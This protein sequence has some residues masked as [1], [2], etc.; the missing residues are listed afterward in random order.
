M[1]DYLTFQNLYDA[2]TNA[3]KD[4]GDSKLDTVKHAIN[5]TYFEMLSADDVYPMFWLLDFDDT[6]NAL[7]EITISSITVAD[8]GVITASAVHGLATSDIVSVYGIVGTMS[9]LNNRTYL[10]NSVPLTTTLSLIDLDSLD[11]IATTGL[12]RTSGGTIVHRGKVLG[13]TGKNV[14]RIH[15]VIFHGE[16]EHLTEITAK[17]LEAETKWW[18]SST[19]RPMRYFHRKRYS[20]AGTESNQLLWFPGSDDAYDL[21]Y[22]FEGRPSV[23]SAVGDVPLMPPQ[24]HYGISAGAIARLA[25]FNVQVENQVIWPAIY[26]KTLSDM[27]AFNRRWWKDNDPTRDPGRQGKPYML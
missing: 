7:A 9:A 11:A 1:A 26:K 20:A 25:E 12:A 23:L 15:D 14:Q 21:R 4:Y 24:F 8:P 19:S 17:E 18:D 27:I 13:V 16:S 3:I 5:M 22:W 2:I 6:L 10:V